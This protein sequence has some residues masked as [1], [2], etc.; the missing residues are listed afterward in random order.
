MGKNKEPEKEGSLLIGVKRISWHKG[1]N[2]GQRGGETLPPMKKG[3]KRTHHVFAGGF[4]GL[5][6]GL[7]GDYGK[8]KASA[9]A[10]DVSPKKGALLLDQGG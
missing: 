9:A 6:E 1:D 4:E 3:G 8:S 7:R 2:T 5:E 10:W